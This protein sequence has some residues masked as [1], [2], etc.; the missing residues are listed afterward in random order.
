K[1]DNLLEYKDG[2]SF[3]LN[4]GD[5]QNKVESGEGWSYGAE[6]LFEKK[7]GKTTGWIGYTLSRTDRQFE[8]LNNGEKFPYRYD[9]RHD[10]SVALTHKFNDRVDVGVVWVYGTGNAVTLPTERYR[11]AQGFNSYTLRDVGYIES[12]NNYRMPSYHRLDIGV[13]L[14]KETKYG[15]R[16]WSFG[17]YNAYSRQNPFFLYF[18]NDALGNTRLTQLSIFPIIPSFSYNF[19]F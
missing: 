5:W 13:N 19:K 8:N 7:T 18:S 15:S 6:I 14:H 11:S 2:A 1:M 3:L 12:R 17:L 16:T 10:I 4:A 9:R